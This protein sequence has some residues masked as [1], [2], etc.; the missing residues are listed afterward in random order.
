MFNW[1][2]SWPQAPSFVISQISLLARNVSRPLW[3]NWKL[4]VGFKS[5][6]FS[7]YSN[8]WSVRLYRVGRPL[9]WE[10]AGFAHHSKLVVCLFYFPNMSLPCAAQSVL[11]VSTYSTPL[12]S[13]SEKMLAMCILHLLFITFSMWLYNIRF[14][15]KLSESEI[16]FFF[17]R[18]DI[19]HWYILFP[20]FANDNQR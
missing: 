1:T 12:K 13:V 9:V 5:H 4:L 20:L 3:I 17:R 14:P 6:L 19:F 11:W 8:G 16:L 7:S 10:S 15:S 2:R 18:I